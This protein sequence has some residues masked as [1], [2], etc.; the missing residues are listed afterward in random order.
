MSFNGLWRVNKKGFN[1][2][3]FGKIDK[4]NYDEEE[5]KQ[6]SKMIQTVEFKVSDFSDL[7]IHAKEG[8]FVYMDPPYVPISDTSSFTRY[9]KEAFGDNEHQK[10]RDVCDQLNNKKV[11]FLVSNSFCDRTKKL[12]DGYNFV[13]V[14]I[15]RSMAANNSSRGVIKE[16]LIKNY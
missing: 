10:L 7:L 12:F 3:P 4:I 9:V 2:S 15:Q 14:E 13:E 6:F 16:L 11:N 1:N 8:D 5:I